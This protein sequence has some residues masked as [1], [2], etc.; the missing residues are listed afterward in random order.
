VRVTCTVVSLFWYY[1]YYLLMPQLT[2]HSLGIG[3]TVSPETFSHVR[4]IPPRRVTT[5]T[6]LIATRAPTVHSYYV[7]KPNGAKLNTA[8][9]TRH[10]FDRPLTVM[11]DGS[12]DRLSPQECGHGNTNGP[13]RV[14]AV[15]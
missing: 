9:I 14:D 12:F 1:R 6:K 15:Q 2:M 10:R 7:T 5:P 4:A 8:G 3:A 13:S 11:A